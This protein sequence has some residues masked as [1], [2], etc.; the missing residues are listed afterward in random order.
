MLIWLFNDISQSLIMPFF[1]FYFK[2]SWLRVCYDFELT[3]KSRRQKSYLNRPHLTNTP[4]PDLDASP[5]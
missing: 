5:C 2:L 1:P 4:P 3:K